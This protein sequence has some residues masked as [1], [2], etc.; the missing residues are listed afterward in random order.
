MLRH[1][2]SLSILNQNEKILAVNWIWVV[3][4][5]KFLLECSMACWDL[6][7]QE[8]G[9][10]VKWKSKRVNPAW[11]WYLIWENSFFCTITLKNHSVLENSIQLLLPQRMVLNL[12]R[13][14]LLHYS[15]QESLARIQY[16]K[17]NVLA[18]DW[19][20]LV[21]S[22]VKPCNYS[23]MSAMH[24]FVCIWTYRFCIDIFF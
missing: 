22:V 17:N 2:T 15:P 6:W 5:H 18:L 11:G 9:Y 13:T 14:H 23:L 4:K 1:F 12:G 7:H 20:C 24:L 3:L 19:T 21:P 10:S 16:W 8:L